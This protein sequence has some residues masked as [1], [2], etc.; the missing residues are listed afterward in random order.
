MSVERIFE[1]GQSHMLERADFNDPCVVDEHIDQPALGDHV[2]DGSVDVGSIPDVATN[3][4]R[5]ETAT[6]EI[7]L[8]ARQLH[9]V[10]CGERYV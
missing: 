6:G 9:F 7:G 4:R 1:I 5:S 8:S 3:D 2:L 10:A